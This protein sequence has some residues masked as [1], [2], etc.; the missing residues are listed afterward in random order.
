MAEIRGLVLTFLERL[1][2]NAL[3]KSRKP[4]TLDACVIQTRVLPISVRAFLGLFSNDIW[5]I[6]SARN[7]FHHNVHVKYQTIIII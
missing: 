3:P 6:I 7:H 2:Q 4:E 1:S 5:V